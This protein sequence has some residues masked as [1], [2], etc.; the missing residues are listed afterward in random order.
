MRTIL[1][2]H[3]DADFAEQLAAEL[4]A[5]GYRVI[6]CPRP[7]P[8]VRDIVWGCEWARRPEPVDRSPHRSAADR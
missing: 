3:R 4:R 1:I 2:A 5:W 7:L 8:R 6:D